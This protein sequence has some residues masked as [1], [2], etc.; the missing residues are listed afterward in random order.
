MPFMTSYKSWIYYFA[1]A[2]LTETATA[3]VAPTIGLLP[4]PIKPIISI[5]SSLVN[6]FEKKFGIA[7]SLKCIVKMIIRHQ[8]INK[9]PFLSDL[10]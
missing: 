1:N 6:S 10:S 7:C 2:W 5:N 8:F 9:L 4:I 3:T